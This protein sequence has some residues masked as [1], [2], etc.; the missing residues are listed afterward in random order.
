MIAGSVLSSS[1]V[2]PKYC[3]GTPRTRGLASAST[4]ATVP[5]TARSG[6]ASTVTSARLA[7]DEPAGVGLEHEH[8]GLHRVQARDLGEL[9]CPGQTVSPTFGRFPR[10]SRLSTRMPS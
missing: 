6:W 5:L 7:R 4:S 2:A 1:S 8:L 3:T 9:G 10:Q